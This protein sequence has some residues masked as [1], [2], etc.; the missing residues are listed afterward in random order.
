MSKN[1]VVRKKINATEE[2]FSAGD[3]E[4]SLKSLKE[5]VEVLIKKYGEE[6]YLNYDKYYCQPYDNDYYPSFEV[7]VNRDETDEEMNKRLEQ[8][9]L[10]SEQIKKRELAELARLQEKYKKAWSM[11]V[12]I[13]YLDQKSCQTLVS[14][15]VDYETMNNVVLP[16]E[17]PNTLGAKFSKEIGE[18]ILE[19]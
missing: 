15:G 2:I 18:W 14:H 1:K 12:L 11:I 5:K 8:E 7:K 17:P 6:A 9:N 19:N 13:T 10:A 4:G 16:N 3:F